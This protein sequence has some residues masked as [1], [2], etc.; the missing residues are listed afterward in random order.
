ML[1]DAVKV[2]LGPNGRNVVEKAFGMARIAKD[3]LAV[4]NEIDLADSHSNA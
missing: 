4:A 1:A 2:T 3:A